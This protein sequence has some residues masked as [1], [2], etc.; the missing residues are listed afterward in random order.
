M[1]N[2]LDWLWHGCRCCVIIVIW[3]VVSIE[4]ELY[5]SWD[6]WIVMLR[7]DIVDNRLECDVRVYD[8]DVDIDVGV[9]YHGWEIDRDM[10]SI[11][12]HWVTCTI[13]RW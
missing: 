8:V 7:E 9:D 4:N 2:I 5:M 6:L 10:V 13:V 11:A 1:L 12:W 3:E